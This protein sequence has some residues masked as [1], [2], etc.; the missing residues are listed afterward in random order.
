MPLPLRLLSLLLFA[1]ALTP[2]G[3][4]PARAEQCYWNQYRCA[5]GWVVTN[6]KGSGVNL[7]VRCCRQPRCAVMP[8]CRVGWRAQCRR[9]GECSSVTPKGWTV[10]GGCVQWQCVNETI[11]QNP[12]R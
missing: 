7:W 12:K 6:S 4:E 8:T 10:A 9:Q 11:R 5:P 1:I 2:H 3:S